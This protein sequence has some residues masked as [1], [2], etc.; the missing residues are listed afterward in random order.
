MS[1]AALAARAHSGLG[2]S[3]S[4]RPCRQVG[5]ESYAWQS[6]SWYRCFKTPSIHHRV[7][8]RVHGLCKVGWFRVTA[9]AAAAASPESPGLVLPPSD[10]SRIR[11]A[12]YIGS[13]V[14]LKGCPPEKYPE[15]AVIGRSNVGKSSLINMLTQ[16]DKLAKVSKEPGQPL[17]TCQSYGSRWKYNSTTKP[18]KCHYYLWL[19]TE[20]N[21]YTVPHRCFCNSLRCRAYAFLHGIF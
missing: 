19:H 5:P 15:F 12:V 8:G 2:A 16:N 1:C 21:P 6:E 13:S 14:D 4:G 18:H 3:T 20:D 11:K 7:S 10:F 9:A 17:A